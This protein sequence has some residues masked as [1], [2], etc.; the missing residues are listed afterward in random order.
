MF[1]L[2]YSQFKYWGTRHPGSVT[3]ME[4]VWGLGLALMLAQLRASCEGRC[5]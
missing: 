5:D 1:Q 3:P 4:A 2:V